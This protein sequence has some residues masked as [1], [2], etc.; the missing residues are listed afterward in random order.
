MQ[1]TTKGGLKKYQRSIISKTYVQST[2]KSG[3]TNITI[4]SL[5][6]GGVPLSE[7][8]F[9]II[10]HHIENPAEVLEIDEDEVYNDVE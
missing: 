5:F 6:N 9:N 2:Y 8:L 10:V 1:A 7:V 3:R 4:N